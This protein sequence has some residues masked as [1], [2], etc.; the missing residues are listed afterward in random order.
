MGYCD[1]WIRL[2]FKDLEHIAQG[3]R[4]SKQINCKPRIAKIYLKFTDT[5]FQP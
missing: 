3:Y 1:V 4:I 5:S 2:W